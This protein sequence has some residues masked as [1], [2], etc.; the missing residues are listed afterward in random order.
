VAQLNRQIF[1]GLFIVALFAGTTWW[2]NQPTLKIH[3]TARN[4]EPKVALTYALREERDFFE[5]HG[6]YETSIESLGFQ[7]EYKNRYLYVFSASGSALDRTSAPDGGRHTVL[8]ADTRA[9]PV[10]VN[11]ELLAAIPTEV[12]ASAGIEGTCPR[13]EVTI[14]SAGNA[15]ADSTVDVWSI[16]T[17]LRVIGGAEV[18]AGVPFNHVDDS[19][20]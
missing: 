18:P 13:C 6:C 2:L 9:T 19:K 5:K 15:D 20:R 3:P 7:P 16:S 1:R 12:L 11:E 10:P 17:K 8:L 4:R 14:V